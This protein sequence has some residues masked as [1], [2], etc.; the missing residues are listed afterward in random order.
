MKRLV[1]AEDHK[2]LREG[3]KALL[4]GGNSFEVVAEAGDGV[5]AIRAVE[6]HLPDL[7]LLD[8]SMPI[9]DGMS[10][11]KEIHKRFSDVKILV[12]T[13][14]DSEEFILE[15]L[16]LGA[17]GYCL[18]DSAGSEL[19]LAIN[20]VIEGKSYLSPG[21][22]DK[23]MEGYL[24]DRSRLKHQSSWDTLTRREREVLKLVGEGYRNRE[25][26]NYLFISIKTV[27]KHRSNI[28][29]KLAIHTVSGLTAYAIDKGLVAR[30][31][32]NA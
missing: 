14:H 31:S 28:M 4:S 21:I 17:N 30:L 23:V 12:L 29:K 13:M 26:G 25:I 1:I 20:R 7:L 22:A 19:L 18:K 10:V 3:L 24:H 11:I 5:E 2:I 27:E 15:G 6:K 9:L 8:L 16:R 32:V